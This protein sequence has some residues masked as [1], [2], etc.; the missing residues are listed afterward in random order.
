[1]M[2]GGSNLVAISH[3]RIFEVNVCVAINTISSKTQH[4]AVK[5]YCHHVATKFY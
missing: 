1:M 5:E 3:L 4:I 2:L